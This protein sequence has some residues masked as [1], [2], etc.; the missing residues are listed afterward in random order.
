M[1][2]RTRQQGVALFVALVFLVVLTI[3]GVAAL[4]NNTLQTR[5]TYSASQTNFA[6]QAAETGLQSGESWLASQT[7]APVPSC[8]STGCPDTAAIWP[9]NSPR[10]VTPANLASDSW[11]AANGRVVLNGQS[12]QDST[13]ATLTTNQPK[14]VIED[15]GVDA[16]GSIVTGQGITYKVHYYV[17]SS[18]GVANQSNA[19]TVVQSVYAK[20]F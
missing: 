20:G 1:S 3:I 5:M 18:R 9:I 6:F 4:G 16:S 15:A 17:V 12:I 8:V 10:T 13:G 7:I 2:L 14:Y 19:S 11:F